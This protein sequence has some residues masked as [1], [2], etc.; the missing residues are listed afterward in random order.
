MQLLEDMDLSLSGDEYVKLLHGNLQ[1]LR[2]TA[3]ACIAGKE[4]QRAGTLTAE[5]QNTY[6]EGD[7]LLYDV[8][9]PEK[10]FFPASIQRTL[11]YVVMAQ[12][13]NDVTCKHTNT[14]MVQVFG[15][16]EQATTLA[17]VD[18][19]QFLIET[20]SAYRGDPNQRSKMKFLITYADETT[21]WKS[22]DL[23]FCKNLPYE[24]Y[25]R[26]VP[27][28]YPLV[29]TVTVASA[30]N[31]AIKLVLR[32]FNQNSSDIWTSDGIPSIGKLL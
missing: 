1:S 27:Q 25:C 14:G 26:T 9:G 16:H 19:Q 23:D 12:D 10:N 18:Y 3:A 4:Y 5:L 13:K 15:A 7:F 32:H 2:S 30:R 6:Q 17:Q 21:S 31:A 24:Q 11:T 22:W 28:L 20:I 8:R 29:F